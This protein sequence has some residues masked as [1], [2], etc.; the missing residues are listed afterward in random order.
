[1]RDVRSVPHRINSGPIYIGPLFSASNL[2]AAYSRTLGHTVPML[3]I[4]ASG[5]SP[6]LHSLLNQ[7]LC[8]SPEGD[9]PSWFPNPG[10]KPAQTRSIIASPEI[11]QSRLVVPLLPAKVSWQRPGG[12]PDLRCGTESVIRTVTNSSHRIG[13]PESGS[14]RRH[15]YLLNR[16]RQS[17]M[18]GRPVPIVGGCPHT[19]SMRLNNRTADR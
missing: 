4:G 17:E 14:C 15:F 13:G 8:V 2:C 18:I 1:M 3:G 9:Q 16:G 12:S 5:S 11:V 7:L 19:P 10:H 6:T